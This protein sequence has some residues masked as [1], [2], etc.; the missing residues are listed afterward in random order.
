MTT[1]V[2]GPAAQFIDWGFAVKLPLC[3]EWDKT[4]GIREGDL[5]SMVTF[6]RV[7]YVVR[8]PGFVLC[9]IGAGLTRTM[10]V[11]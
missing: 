7:C 10:A 2:P 11:H 3:A 5:R 1:M 4:L 6:L 8:R 9:D